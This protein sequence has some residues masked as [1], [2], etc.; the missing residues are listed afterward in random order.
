MPYNSKMKQ[1]KFSGNIEEEFCI[2]YT[3]YAFKVDVD[4][5]HG[6]IKFTKR[7]VKRNRSLK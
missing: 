4:L 1:I 5:K 2:E 3:P 6:Q 7:K